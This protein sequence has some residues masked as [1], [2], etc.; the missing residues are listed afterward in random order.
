MTQKEKLYREMVSLN[1]ELFKYG[2]K[3]AEIDADKGV[4]YGYHKAMKVEELKRTISSYKSQIESY[5]EEK[6]REDFYDTENGKAVKEY[7]ENLKLETC[8]KMD[9]CHGR[10]L[11]IL[12]EMLDNMLGEGFKVKYLW[13]NSL[14][15]AKVDE[16]GNVLFGHD[17]S[18]YRDTWKKMQIL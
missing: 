11:D 5:K 2:R 6:K 10:N 12:Q 16:N 7:L 17:W 18:V 1:N 9:S 14:E 4:Y 13:D 15:F 3:S 8:E